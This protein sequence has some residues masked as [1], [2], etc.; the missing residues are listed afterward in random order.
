MTSAMAWIGAIIIAI[1]AL[2]LFGVTGMVLAGAG[3]AWW[4]SNQ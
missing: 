2:Y 4:A 1:G 3:A